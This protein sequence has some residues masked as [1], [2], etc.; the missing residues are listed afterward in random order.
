MDKKIKNLLT[1]KNIILITLGIFCIITSFYLYGRNKSKVFKDE[2]MNNIFVEENN[3]EESITTSGENVITSNNSNKIFVEIKGEVAKPDVYEVDEGSII[4]DLINVAGGLTPE[5]NIDNINRA[6]KLINNQL[7]VIPNKNDEIIVEG[8]N[9]SQGITKDGI[10]NIN[11]ASLSE[12]QEI[13]GIGEVKA[14]SIID[15]REKNG[16]F[17]SIED[18]K[19]VDGIGSKTFE[20]IKEKI[21]I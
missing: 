17:K 21:C 12:L 4:R 6:E 14:Q 20:K 3:S 2:Y 8:T 18:I 15:Y 10:I 19:N 9:I 13:T 11:K 16:G 5:A 7:I 1:L